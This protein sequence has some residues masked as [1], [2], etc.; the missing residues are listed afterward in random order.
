MRFDQAPLGGASNDLP[1]DDLGFELEQIAEQAEAGG[2]DRRLDAAIY[3]LVADDGGRKAFHVDDWTAPPGSSFGRWH[4]G[5][6]V[7]EHNRDP[8]ARDLPR[9]TTSL[10]AA[11][12]LVPEGHAVDLTLW[13]QKHRAR[14]LPLYQDGDRWF[15]RGSDPHFTADA[16]TP[17]LA[18][19]AAALRARASLARALSRKGVA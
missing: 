18:L 5:W 16:G 1:T 12:T 9:Y 8:Y 11:L 3:N 4:D 7:G 2:A 13:A 10:D 17:A 14:I 6:F 19:C 15:H